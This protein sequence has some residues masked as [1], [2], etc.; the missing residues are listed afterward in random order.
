MAIG[1]VFCLFNMILVCLEKA[2]IYTGDLLILLDSLDF[3]IFSG[4]TLY[5]S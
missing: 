2:P 1:Y 5:F 4:A 3:L